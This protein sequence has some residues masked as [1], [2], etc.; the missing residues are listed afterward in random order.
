MKI[1]EKRSLAVKAAAWIGVFLALMALVVWDLPTGSSGDRD[2]LHSVDSEKSRKTI[3]DSFVASGNH[4]MDEL[5]SLRG[6][7]AKILNHSLPYTERARII[8]E[9]D[10]SLLDSEGVDSVKDYLTDIEASRRGDIEL[11]LMSFIHQRW[12]DDPARVVD[13][14][15]VTLA[16]LG[17]REHHPVWREYILQYADRILFWHGEMPQVKSSKSLLSGAINQSLDEIETGV[18][19]TALMALYR[20]KRD[21]LLPIASKEIVERG[22][23]MLNNPG[24]S[25]ASQIAASQVVQSIAGEALS[26]VSGESG[27]VSFK[28]DYKVHSLLEK[29]FKKTE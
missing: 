10:F 19:G 7:V 15:D 4:D 22:L 29:T 23:E 28:G 5:N 2:S 24:T 26:G 6:S 25:L 18:A 8:G 13:A 20:A 14:I 1:T 21:E 3:E 16:V 9:I 12:V 11:S 17:S 27:S